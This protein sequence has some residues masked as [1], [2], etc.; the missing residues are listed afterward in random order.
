MDN[1][2]KTEST[3]SL[4]MHNVGLG[5]PQVSLSTFLSFLY[6]FLL[7]SWHLYLNKR[8]FNSNIHTLV[9]DVNN[10]QY[11]H[12]SLKPWSILKMVSSAQSLS[13]QLD[14]KL[15]SSLLNLLKSI[16]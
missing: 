16:T 13:K 3:I 4:C 15:S 12:S 11:S 8:V 2:C 10:G 5:V 1:L 7:A 6:L 14:S 9:L